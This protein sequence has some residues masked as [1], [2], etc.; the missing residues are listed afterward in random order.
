MTTMNIFDMVDTWNNAGTT[1]TAIKMN[2]TDAASAAASLLLD[3]QVGGSSL[4][5]IR[6]DG[7]L[8]LWPSG[9]EQVR[10]GAR[11]GA[12]FSLYNTSDLGFFD[13][14][15]GG[16][17]VRYLAY[18]SWASSDDATGAGDL[19]LWR[20]AANTLAQR[21]GVNAQA[22]RVYNTFTDA[23]N[24]ERGFVRWSSNVLEIGSEAL[25]TGSARLVQ[26]TSAAGVAIN[27]ANG[28]DILFR[29][30]GTNRW[31]INSSSHF[32]AATDNTYDIGANGATRPR[33]IYVAAAAFVSQAS[34]IPAGGTAGAGLNLSST[35]NFGVY[36]GSGA[37]TLSAA[38][39]SLYLRSDGSSTS[40]RL[41]V[42]T[43]GSTTWTNV[44]TAD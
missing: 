20:D 36:F 34:A 3:L 7:R 18:L 16:M 39:G 23:S 21:N 27:A 40:T 24:F 38:K 33:N 26:L 19:R 29:S 17:Q 35:A 8:S 15:M 2:V 14:Q 4:F 5:A 1:F 9:A 11:A 44:T 37:P 13:A 30:A 12:A 6:K 25:G 41:Y 32:L 22:F 10:V 28:N 42:N 31:L 43:D